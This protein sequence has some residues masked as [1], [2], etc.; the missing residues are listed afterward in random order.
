MLK[1]LISAALIAVLATGASLPSAAPAQ[2][3]REMEAASRS[4]R[5][6]EMLPLNIIRQRVQIDGATLIGADLI[7]PG[8]YRLRFMRGPN[9]LFVDVDGRS[10]RVI[11]C[12]GC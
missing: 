7:G 5:Q 6:G 8:T 10:G 12:Q 9:V 2:P 3:A 4:V 11:R 1:S